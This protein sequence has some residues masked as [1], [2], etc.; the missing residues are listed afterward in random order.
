MLLS[1]G[2]KLLWIRLQG[3]QEIIHKGRHSIACFV[4]PE[5]VPDLLFD[6]GEGLYCCL[7]LVFDTQDMP[8]KGATHQLAELPH[9]EREGRVLKRLHHL[10]TREIA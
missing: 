3:G 1:Q 6:L 7:M 10:P 8:P 4:L 9:R 2:S 5:F